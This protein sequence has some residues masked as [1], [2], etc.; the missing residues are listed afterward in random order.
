[1]EI[2]EVGKKPEGGSG[3]PEKG[4]DQKPKNAITNY[5]SKKT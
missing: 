3:T 5:F 4:E 1:M 2:M